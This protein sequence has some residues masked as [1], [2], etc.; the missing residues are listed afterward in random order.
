MRSKL[1]NTF[2]LHIGDHTF[3]GYTAVYTVILNL[4]VAIVLTPVFNAECGTNAQ[5][6]QTVAADYQRLR[7]RCSR[8][9]HRPGQAR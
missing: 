8:C 9:W 7:H 6:D 4:L 2:P 1:T 5:A 3:P